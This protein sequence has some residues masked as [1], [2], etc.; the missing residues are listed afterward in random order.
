V[1]EQHALINQKGSILVGVVALSLMMTVAAGGFLILAGNSSGDSEDYSSELAFRYAAESA[2]VMG[3]ACIRAHSKSMYDGPW[4][5]GDT[6]VLTPSPGP[7]GYSSFNGIQARVSIHRSPGVPDTLKCIAKPISNTGTLILTWTI[8]RVDVDP[9]NS[10]L[11]IPI[12]SN[13]SESY[14]PGSP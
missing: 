10:T 6:Q 2:L 9:M 11:C 5:G 12:L 13:W 14:Q 8:E 4:S 7:D 1:Q 3:A